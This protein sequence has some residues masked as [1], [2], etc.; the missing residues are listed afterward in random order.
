MK[1]KNFL[2][3]MCI[4]L[5]LSMPLSFA[6]KSYI[7]VNNHLTA[8]VEGE[9]VKYFQLDFNKNVRTVFDEFG[10][11]TSFQDFTP[12]GEPVEEAVFR[13]AFA[14]RVYDSIVKL[15][16]TYNPS[17]SRTLT[18]HTVSFDFQMNPQGFNLYAYPNNN[19]FRSTFQQAMSPD[20]VIPEA[21]PGASGKMSG[22]V[23]G[24]ESAGQVILGN[25]GSR[26]QEAQAE[27]QKQFM[28]VAT[29]VASV[30]GSMAG[31]GLKNSF[32]A[33]KSSAA[34]ANTESVDL[35]E[36]LAAAEASAEA[37]RDSTL[38]PIPADPVVAPEGVTGSTAGHILQK[39]GVNVKEI[40]N[41]G[42]AK[43][44]KF[45]VV[46][47]NGVNTYL[48][49][50]M[51]TADNWGAYGLWKTDIYVGASMDGSTIIPWP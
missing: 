41:A 24:V 46:N 5:V 34:E 29:L 1:N 48:P 40:W 19:P 32:E 25:L 44:P 9:E 13:K 50:T 22:S 26:V 21:P 12:F 37:F 4:F 6:G 15:Y 36:Q 8:Q 10:V 27:A 7:N 3:V 11:P 20:T 47:R 45:F 51:K 35:D 39:L 28:A 2:A 14:S 42:F 18:P 43:A 33:D 49:I 17:N 30:A 31:K 23:S 16:N 38:K